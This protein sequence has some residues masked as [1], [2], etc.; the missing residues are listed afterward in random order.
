MIFIPSTIRLSPY[1]GVR[2]DGPSAWLVPG[3]TALDDL[4]DQTG[5]E[6]PDNAGRTASGFVTNRLGRIPSAGD[7]V[8]EAGLRLTVERMGDR[9]VALLRIEQTAPAPTEPEKEDAQ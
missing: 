6:L 9:R 2:P 5:L 4:R 1:S 8:E 3:A 7:S